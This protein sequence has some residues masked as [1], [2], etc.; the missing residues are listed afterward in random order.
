MF[1]KYVHANEFSVSSDAKI[2]KKKKITVFF[3]ELLKL[4][5]HSTKAYGFSTLYVP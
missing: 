4:V 2:Q 1:S 5:D 3:G